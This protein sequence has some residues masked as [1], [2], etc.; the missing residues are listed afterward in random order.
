MADQQP[1]VPLNE[2][3]TEEKRLP[4]IT[5]DP[6]GNPRV[7]ERVVKQRYI[8]VPLIPHQI[9]PSGEHTFAFVALTADVPSLPCDCIQIR[10]S[11]SSQ[12]MM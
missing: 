1:Y 5:L 12:H 3:Q 2:W 11:G 10:V 6:R 8:H 4:T 7:G 9:S